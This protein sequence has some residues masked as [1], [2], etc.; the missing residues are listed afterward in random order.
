M[1]VKPVPEGFHTVTPYLVATDAA[2][3]IDFI[4][5]GLA[6]QERFVMRR[7]DGSIGHA[8]M[9]VGDSHVMIGQ[10]GGGNPAFPAM[11]YLYV[12]D[13]DALFKQ[14]VAA[15]AKALHEPATQFYGDRHGAVVDSNGN[16]W[17]IATHVED[18]SQEELERRAAAAQH[19]PA[20]A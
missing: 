13:V 8:E 14:A 9:Q 20:T 1:A 10:A 2:A 11:L 17:W 6:G 12:P 15:G 3:L 19:Q 16:Q 5:R 7:P 4:T 18:V